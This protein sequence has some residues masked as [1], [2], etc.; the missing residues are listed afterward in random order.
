LEHRNCIRWQ[1]RAVGL[2]ST[3][4]HGWMGHGSSD[5]G[6]ASQKSRSASSK[7]WRLVTAGV[8][9]HRKRVAEESKRE[10]PLSSRTTGGW[11]RKKGL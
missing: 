8:P 6:V 7:E 11:V 5:P 1:E 3:P 9:V 4:E 2:S 10:R